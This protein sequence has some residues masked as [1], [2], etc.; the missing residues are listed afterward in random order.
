MNKQHRNVIAMAAAMAA[1]AVLGG[2][3]GHAVEHDRPTH[4]RAP[5][6]PMVRITD[7][8][9]DF[10]SDAA[11]V[12]HEAGSGT[13]TYDVSRVPHGTERI[14]FYVS[15]SP[16]SHYEVTMGKA[17]AGPCG[18]VVGN[19]GGIPLSGAGHRDVTIKLPVGTKFWLVG[20]PEEE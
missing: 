5:I 4:T 13:R 2:C 11:P 3:S 17:F 12:L 18:R 6:D 9:D 8:S 20:I 10:Y 16:D 7:K 19:S 14:T 1:I 15:C